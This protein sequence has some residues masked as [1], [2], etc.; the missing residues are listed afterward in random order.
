MA[1]PLTDE[2]REKY[3]QAR[4]DR[5]TALKGAPAASARDD[6]A[7]SKAPSKAPKPKPTL[8]LCSAVINGVE[9]IAMMF[10]HQT[11]D[12]ERQA[13][14]NGLMA[15][16]R[17]SPLIAGLVCGTISASDYA[18]IVIGLGGL[19]ARIGSDVLTTR[20]PEF[21]PKRDSVYAATGVAYM[22]SGAAGELD[23]TG[24]FTQDEETPDVETGRARSDS[25]SDGVGED[26]LGK[27]LTP[28]SQTRPYDGEQAG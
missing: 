7:P 13:A 24:L 25:G 10:G 12:A 23:L 15:A 19:V 22:M 11:E 8:K 1:Q 18:L 20:N 27:I 3:N 14:T 28:I 26:V 5:A 21:A 4:R 16:C 17:K 9:S 6:K 2:Q